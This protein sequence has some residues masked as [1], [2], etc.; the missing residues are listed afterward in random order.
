MHELA[1]MG[2][3]SI[4]RKTDHPVPLLKSFELAE[5]METIAAGRNCS[6][7]QQKVRASLWFRED[8]RY[9]ISL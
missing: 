2:S 8:F 7:S 5:E 9:C 1:G 4:V 3:A 6:Q